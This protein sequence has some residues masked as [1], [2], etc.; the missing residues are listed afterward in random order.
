MNFRPTADRSRLKFLSAHGT[1]LLLATVILLVSSSG[2]GLLSPTGT[3]R[4][5]SVGVPAPPPGTLP[6]RASGSPAPGLVAF[7][8]I[9]LNATVATIPAGTDVNLTVDFAAYAGYLDA[10][11]TNVEF[12]YPNGTAIPAWLQN[13]SSSTSKASVVWLDLGEPLVRGLPQTILLGILG[14]DHYNLGT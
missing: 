4:S 13:G 1:L 6:L 8:P 11:L 5:P 10:N 14:P 3:G 7:V 9:R 12:L 2:P